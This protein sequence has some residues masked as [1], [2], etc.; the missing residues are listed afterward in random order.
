MSRH[1]KNC[2][3]HS[4]FTHGEKMKLLKESGSTGFGSVTGRIGVDSQKKFDQCE[5]CLST[6]PNG[7][8][9]SMWSKSSAPV[10]CNQ[11]HLF[12]RDCI[13]ENLAKQKKD[14]DALMKKHLI[15]LQ[16]NE[17]NI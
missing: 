13:I 9:D 12:W 15:L 7:I 16:L 2:T 6:V 4:I 1:S 17:S 3:A 14:K 11:G 8:F 10:C 5:L